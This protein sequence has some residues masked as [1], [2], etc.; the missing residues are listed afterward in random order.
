MSDIDRKIL[1]A[2]KAETDV[3]MRGYERELGF[4]GL[5][6]E[7]FRGRFGWMVIGA[8]AMQVVVAVALVYCAFGLYG[9]D[10][11]AAKLDWLAPGLAAF[12][13][14]G[15]LRIWYFMEINRLSISREVKRLELQVA[16]VANALG[17]AAGEG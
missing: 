7:S 10:D 13:A 6:A 16:A 5:M 17:R 9:T 3:T 12:F 14:F 15:L 11:P 8:I 4:F 1:E 2:I